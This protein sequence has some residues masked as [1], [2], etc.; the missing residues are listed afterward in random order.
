[1]II[2]WIVIPI[3]LII[4]LFQAYADTWDVECFKWYRVLFITF[5]YPFIIG[6]QWLE[7]KRKK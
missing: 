7:W 6:W 4:G 3:Y 5:F 2:L 1:M